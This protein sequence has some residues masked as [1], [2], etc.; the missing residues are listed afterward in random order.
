MT[1]HMDIEA[2]DAAFAKFGRDLTAALIEFIDSLGPVSQSMVISQ[3]AFAKLM[4]ECH[5]LKPEK[6]K[7]FWQQINDKHQ[8]AKR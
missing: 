2:R 6:Q 8:R 7:P 3:E 4:D 5:L 1:M